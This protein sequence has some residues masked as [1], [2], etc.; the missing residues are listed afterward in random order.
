MGRWS[1]TV[2]AVASLLVLDAGLSGAEGCRDIAFRRTE[3]RSERS[4][5]EKPSGMVPLSPG[6]K[7]MIR[8]S[9]SNL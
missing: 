2:S 1:R 3:I 4:G 6:S 5:E 8:L 7:H 9:S